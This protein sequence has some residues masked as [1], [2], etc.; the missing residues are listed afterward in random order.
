MGI[1]SSQGMSRERPTLETAHAP[2]SIAGA[3]KDAMAQ[4][5]VA[6]HCCPEGQSALVAHVV[7][8][9]GTGAQ[10]PPAQTPF[11]PVLDEH[12]VPAGG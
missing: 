5:P 3:G 10:M 8:V 7:F 1:A 2:G 9:G 12:T 4:R 6:S 11:V